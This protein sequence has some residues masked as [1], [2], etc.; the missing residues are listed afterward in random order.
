MQDYENMF[1]ENWN[2]LYD[3]DWNYI[4]EEKS[5][6]EELI[7]KDSNWNILKKWDTIVAIKDLQ[8]KKGSDI[9]RWDKFKNIKFTDDPKIVESWGWVLKTEFFKKV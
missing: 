9:K 4:W 6:S 1:D 7:V 8:V 2:Y 3:D 5:N